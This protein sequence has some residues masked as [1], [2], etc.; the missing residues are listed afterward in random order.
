MKTIANF[1]VKHRLWVIGAWLAFIVVAQGI[2]GALGGAAYKDTF[3]LPHTET[4]SVAKVLK[5]AGLQN[6]NGAT[7]TVVLNAKTGTLSSAPTALAP[8]L[9][10]LCSAGYDVAGIRTPWQSVDCTKNAAVTAGDPKLLNTANGSTTGL[11]DITWTSNHYDQ[12]L[13][14]GAYNNLKTLRSSTLQV[15]FTGNAFQGVGQNQGVPPF[16]FGFIAAL[17]ILIF[18]FRT[19]GA[20]V[21]PL[22]SAIGALGAGLGLIGILTHA[23]N[24]SNITPELTE[25]MVLGVGVD[26]ALFIVTRHRR[27]LRRGIGLHESIVTSMDTS[28]RAVLFAATTVCIALLGLLALGVSFFNGMAIGAA[29]AVSLTAAASLTLLPALLSLFGLKVLPRKQRRAVRAGEFIELHATGFWARWSIT[30]AR[31]KTLLSLGAAAVIVVLALPFFSMR[32]GAGDQGNDPKGSTTRS[33]YD[34]IATGFG[35]GYNSTL[36][37]VVDGPGATDPA[38]LQKVSTALQGTT[39]VEPT[40]VHAIPLNSAV[41]FVSFKSTTS[42]QDA[43]TYALVKDLRAHT[44]PPVYSGTANHIYVYGDT[45]IQVDFAKVLAA[46]LPIFIAAVVG[47]SFLLLLVAFR[48]LVIPLTAAVMNLLAAGASFGVV[49]AIFQYGWGADALGLGKGGPIDAWAPV[50]FFAILFGLSMDYQVFLVSRMYEEWLHTHDNKRAVIVGQAETGSIITAA[51]LI[52][53]AVFGGFVLGDQRAIKIFGIGLATA[54]FLDAFLLR[55]ILVPS[56][57]HVL[58]D[59]NWYLPKWIDRITPKVSFEPP[60]EPIAEEDSVL[61]GNG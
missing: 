22:A 45:A 28:G 39:G 48:S 15:E 35:V 29:V 47:L 2:S 34:L 41:A 49:V 30:V 19:A 18:V 24:V 12:R 52:M 58:G 53:I 16:L 31:H 7:G 1:A 9:T 4:A 38:Y 6:Q 20:T 40:S 55:T 3:S 8:A 26:Y 33:G 23:M 56:L 51:A 46:K 50:M 21:L 11:V 13:F 59:R 32:L 17:I 61:V 37:A 57:M 10:K 5:N 14:T 25:L 27:N 60:D 44:L 36:E 54:V 43:K 42:P